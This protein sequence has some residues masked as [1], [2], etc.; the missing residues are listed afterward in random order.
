MCDNAGQYLEM[1]PVKTTSAL[2]TARCLYEKYYMRHGFI[3][4]LISDRAQSYLANF[5]Q[6]LFKICKIRSLQTSSFHPQKNSLAE[7]QNKALIIGLRTHLMQKRTDWTRQIPTVAFAHNVAVI[8]SQAISPFVILFNSQPR[9]AVD[10]NVL[11]AARQSTVPGFAQAFL[12]DFEAL[13]QAVAQN[14]AENKDTVQKHQF[15]R[16]RQHNFKE[17]DLL[18]KFDF[19]HLT[20]NSEKLKPK[21]KGP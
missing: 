6:E 13:C 16:A 2:K 1:C 14:I 18:Y 21:W 9:L 12:A 7:I 19:T 15:A 20:D 10:A 3:P 17:G 4:N 11:Q 8:P 5:M